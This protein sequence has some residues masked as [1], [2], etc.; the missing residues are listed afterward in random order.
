M[1]MR[2]FIIVA[3]VLVPSAGHA[4][5]YLIPNETA[6]D[7]GLSESALANQQGAEAGIINPAALA[8]SEGLD[9]SA[10]GEILVN[11]TDWSD[12]ALGSASIR[13]QTTTPPAAAISYG[14]K[15][16]GDMAWGAGVA[17]D[18]PA[19]GSLFWQNSWPGQEYIRTVD[20]RVYQIAFAAGFQPLPYLK[21]GASYNRYQA[22]EELHQGINYLDHVGDAGI[23][24]SGGTNGFALAAEFKVSDPRVPLTLAATYHYTSSLDL[25]GHAH[26]TDVP[27]AFQPMLH[28][29]DVTENLT[30]PDKFFV[31]AAYE[32]MPNLKV[33]AAYDLERWSVYKSDTFVGSSGLTISVP[34]NYNN[35]HVF[36]GG[37]EWQK[38][39][40]APDLTLR[41]GFLIDLSDQP[42]DTVSPT[43]TDGDKVGVS[44]GGG[45]EVIP[46][47]RIDL[48]YQHV[49]YSDVSAAMSSEALPGTYKS[50][51]DL[52][53]I[54]V[55]W[56][57]DLAFLKK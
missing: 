14:Q 15:L 48:G 22:T 47:L 11:R 31:G 2:T 39:P 19:G 28:D 9:V 8:G 20:Q 38:T 16:E 13:P 41:A 6:R 24:M 53:S 46:G 18:V 3:T 56:R 50:S 5:G 35:A 44:I 17:F 52:I 30:I 34:R 26:F 51:A 49:F 23:A 21:L 32:V 29:Q 7:L 55:N 10:N 33:M 40:F 27:E 42:A 57:S 54:G 4:G 36:R 37:A 45:Y 25:S 12:P 43:L 1:T